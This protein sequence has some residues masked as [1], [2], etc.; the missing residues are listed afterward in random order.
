MFNPSFLKNSSG[1]MPSPLPADAA[2]AMAYV[3]FQ[4]APVI[5]EDERKALNQGTV[6]PE[7]DKPFYGKGAVQ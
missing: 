5:Y 1:S 2:V 3:P 6:F 4:Q 7:L